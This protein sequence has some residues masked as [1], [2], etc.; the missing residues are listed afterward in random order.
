MSNGLRL[1]EKWYKRGLWLVAVVFAGLL[2]GLG[3]TLIRHLPRVER[4][5]AVDDFMDRVSARDLA[6]AL[7]AAQ[8]RGEDARQA[9]DL[10]ALLLKKAE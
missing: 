1:S 9:Q 7:K 6:D 2:I 4:P 10:A 3:S 5:L 8:H